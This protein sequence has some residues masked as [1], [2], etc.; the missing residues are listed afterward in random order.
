VLPREGKDTYRIRK[1]R[2]RKSTKENEKE[3]IEWLKT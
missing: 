3:T 1:E 2:R